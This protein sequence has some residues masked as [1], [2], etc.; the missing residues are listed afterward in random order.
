MVSPLHLTGVGCA[1]HVLLLML[2]SREGV[3]VLDMR[4][5][6]NGVLGTF[7]MAR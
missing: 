2:P 3:R 7:N 6:N 5:L 1:I 4:Y